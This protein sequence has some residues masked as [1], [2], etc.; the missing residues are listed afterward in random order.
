[1]V[2]NVWKEVFSENKKN[3]QIAA[4]G[5]ET[6]QPSADNRRKY[7]NMNRLLVDNA[8]SYKSE[9]RLD[10]LNSRGK[11]FPLPSNTVMGIEPNDGINFNSVQIVNLD[12]S[13]AIAA[14]DI[15]IRYAKAERV[16]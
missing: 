16:F 1:M 8:S 9:I 14:D 6:F 7:T 12:G 13:N 5:S 11:V 2:T 3:A 10:G 15:T 4:S